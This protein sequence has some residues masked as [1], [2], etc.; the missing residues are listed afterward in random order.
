MITTVVVSKVSLVLYGVFI[1]I[2]PSQGLTEFES[3]KKLQS[4]HAKLHLREKEMEGHPC[5]TVTTFS[6]MPPTKRGPEKPLDYDRIF[7]ELESL[8]HN[9]PEHHS[10]SL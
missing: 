9:L 8:I 4:S 3:G 5:T 7:Y 6:T 10:N 2:I 1:S